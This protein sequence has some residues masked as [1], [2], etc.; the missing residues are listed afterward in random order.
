MTEHAEHTEVRSTPAATAQVHFHGT[1]GEY[2]RIWIV[3]IALTIVTLGIYSA[4]AKVRKLR[5]LYNNTELDGARFEYHAKP[6][7]ILIGRLIAVALLAIYWTASYYSP[8]AGM[9][10]VLAIMLLVPVLVVRSRIFQMRN[11]SY[12]QIRFGFEKNYKGAFSA[13]YLG[14]LLTVITLGFGAP[15][16]AYMRHKFGID[17]SAFGQTH[18]QFNGTSGKFFSIFYTALGLLILGL[19]VFIFV[20]IPLSPLLPDLFGDGTPESTPGVLAQLIVSAPTFLIYT[21]VAVYGLVRLR[22]YVWN[23]TTLSGHSFVSTMSVRT[24]FWLYVTNIV[25]IICTIGLLIPW[26]TI[27]LAKYRADQTQVLMTGDWNQ[28]LADQR[29]AGSSI[30]EEVG[31]AFDVGIDLA[32]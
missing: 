27:R 26:A 10:V 8:A 25:A 1:S 3:N 22:N 6:V 2:F 16:A 29:P 19:I 7:A 30:G 5:Y 23:N 32:F 20:L 31:E 14:A 13:Y 28:F 18:F 12:R 21:A 15:Q 4:W 11:T 9:T 17:N 24:M